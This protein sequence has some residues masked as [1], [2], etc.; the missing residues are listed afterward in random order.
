MK[1]KLTIIIISLIVCSSVGIIIPRLSGSPVEQKSTALTNDCDC[2]SQETYFTDVFGNTYTVMDQPIDCRFLEKTNSREPLQ[3]LPA[4][5]S[6]KNVEGVDWTTPAKHQGN[7]GS[8]WDFA[9]L[10][11]LESRIQI[12]EQ[13]PF[14]KPDLS[15]QYVL[16][17]LPAAANNYGLGCYG[18]TPYGAYYY[19]MNS[20]E[21]GNN[22]NGI[23]PESCF[24]YQASHTVP[25]DEKCEEWMDHLVPITDCSV[26]FLDLGYATKENTDVIKTILL[27]DGPLAVALNV[28]Q[29]FINYWSIT[30][31]P[32][33]YYPD[34][35]EPWGN[36]LNHIVMLVGWK[37]DASIKNGGYWIVKNSWG[38][39]WGY[40]GFFNLEYYA[41]FFGMYYATA[42]YDP[43]S[44]NWPPVA[45][46][47]GFY[48]AEPEEIL[49]FDGT[50]SIDPEDAVESYQWDFGDGT[51]GDGPTTTH[52]YNTAG[53]Y[54]VT[55]IVTDNS[56]KQ[57][58]DKTL[59]G[60]G[61]DP[62]RIDATGN[63]GIDISIESNGDVGATTVD[64][65]IEF[66]GLVFTRGSSGIIPELS[67][68]QPFT[69]HIQVLGLGP[70]RVTIT[71]ETIQHTERFLMLGPIVFGLRLQ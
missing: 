65:C 25:C 66:S 4:E 70:G 54:S 29:Q 48:T 2:Q 20:T 61:Q 13:C 44:V 67:T 16:S 53:V 55:L 18:G 68:Q 27:E 21:E 19:I 49:T 22:V 15:E 46:A 26:T 45:D 9:A 34:T 51:I 58:V 47:G 32:E 60:I 24:P 35:Q 59:V 38:T 31:N 69:K 6:W 7:C 33:K 36:M 50:A 10:G 41:L 23:I 12:S 71:V 52:S 37:D 14:I 1:K 5:F 62:V 30:H 57:G 42:S 8:C 43:E 17:C 56:G 64:W 11:A 3:T 63:R 28:T 40:E 39:D